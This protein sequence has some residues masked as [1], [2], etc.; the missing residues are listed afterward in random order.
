M[1]KLGILICSMGMVMLLGCAM[2][3][4]PGFIFSDIDVPMCSPDDSSGLAPGPKTGTSKMINYFGLI[5]TG[6][7]SIQ[8]AA[9]NGGIIKVKTADFHYDTILGIIN[10]TTTTVTGE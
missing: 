6:D 3:Y 5:A 8:A 9:K 1:K 2:P 10:T 4:S 7:A